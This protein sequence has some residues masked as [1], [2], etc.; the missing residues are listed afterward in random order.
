MARRRN[1]K[2]RAIAGIM[3]GN[4]KELIETATRMEV[5]KEEAMVAMVRIVKKRL[6]IIE[7]YVGEG[8][9]RTGEK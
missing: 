9:E 3:M 1:K 2:G 8:I 6:K 4:R 7:V 5:E